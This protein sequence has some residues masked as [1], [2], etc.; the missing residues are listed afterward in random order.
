MFVYF[1][2]FQVRCASALAVFQAGS[3]FF[4]GSFV[5]N[6]HEGV[7]VAS[8]MGGIF[9]TFGVGVTLFFDTSGVNTREAVIHAFE[10]AIRVF[11]AR[12]LTGFELGF[13]VYFLFVCGLELPVIA[14]AEHDR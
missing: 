4:A 10:F 13:D 3:A 5:A 8:G 1:F 6:T 12:F 2:A 7:R 14:G 11:A 9:F